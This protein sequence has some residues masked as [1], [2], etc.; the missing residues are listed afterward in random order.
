MKITLSELAKKLN[1]QLT[2]DP[3]CLVTGPATLENA[4]PE[5][6]TFITNSQYRKFL[7]NCQAGVVIGTQSDL[8]DYSGNSLI[9]SV[10]YVSYAIAASL[11]SPDLFQA[12]GVHAS[13]VVDS[14][15]KLSDSVSIGA[16]SVIEAD[17][18][19]SGG[20]VIGAGCYIAQNCEIGEGSHISA[21]VSLY[22]ECTIGRDSIVHSGAVIGADGFGFANDDGSWIKVPQLGRVC[23]GD[24][25]EIGA[26]T[27]IDRGAI[28]NTVIEDGVKIDN[29]VQ[30]AHNVNIGANTAIA[31]C[32]GIAGST[33]IGKNCAIAGGVGLL[34]HLEIVDG[35]T[36]TAMSMVTK[37]ITKSGVYSSGTPLEDN[38]QWHK[39]F[40]RFKQLDEMTRRVRQL[41]KEL[42]SIK[43]D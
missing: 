11:F 15:V 37:S 8:N 10:P 7:H 35:V 19:L 41:E 3:D 42:K 27:T 22:H 29:L 39:N 13:A 6:F 33:R 26:N 1:A 12:Q 14:S 20:V 18:I 30:I 5:H 32:V 38:K 43:E 17:V 36:V 34:G 23:I 2:G 31:G 28:E 21:N 24:N 9:V 25:V 16:N 4:G 40:V